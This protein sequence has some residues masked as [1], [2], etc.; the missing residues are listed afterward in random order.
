MFQRKMAY[1]KG[2][3]P[4]GGATTVVLKN[5]TITNR[6]LP[7]LSAV[8]LIIFLVH[9]AGVYLFSSG[10]L[11]SRLELDTVNSCGL[12]ELDK[13][14][15][16]VDQE[17]E[18]IS[19]HILPIHT[20]GCWTEGR[21]KRVVLIVVDALRFDFTVYNETLD[22]SGE[23][24][25][26]YLNKLP[27]IRD[28]LRDKPERS[29][30]VRVRADAPTTT[31]Q[32][33]KALTTGT[34]PTFVDAGSNFGVDQMVRLGKKISFMGDDTWVGLYPTQMNES[35]PYPSFN[36]QDLH[37]VDN[38]CV[39]HLFPALERQ[40]K[41]WD[42]L[43]A[44]FLGVD[45]VGH[46]F[47]PNTLPCLLDE[48]T[49]AFVIGDHGMDP[50]GDHGGDSENEVNAAL[51][52]YSGGK[53]LV[54]V[55]NVDGTD[56]AAKQLKE[57]LQRLE[58]VPFEGGEPYTYLNGHRTMPQI[59]LVPTLSLLIGLPIPFGN[60]GTIIPELF[61]VSDDADSEENISKSVAKLLE[62]TRMNARQMYRYLQDYSSQRTSADF[63]LSALK[64]TFKTFRLTKDE[65]SKAWESYYMYVV[66]M[67]KSLVVARRI[68]ARFDVPLI[69]MGCTVLG[70][71]LASAAV[72]AMLDWISIPAPTSLDR[73]STCLNGLGLRISDSAFFGGL[74]AGAF[75]GR[76]TDAA[77]WFIALLPVDGEDSVLTKT[78]EVL[79]LSTTTAMIAYITVSVLDFAR[80][81][82]KNNASS[83]LL[84]Q[85]FTA[86]K[87]G[88]VTGGT[89][90]NI[91]LSF[92]LLF[93][94]A[95][96][97]TSNSFTIHDE[98]V[99]AYLLQG[100]GL[101]TLSASFSARN[102]EARGSL[103]MHSILFMV[104]TR[105]SQTSTIC[106][107]ETLQSMMCYP[108]FNLVPNSSVAS[109]QAVLALLVLVPIVVGS[110]RASIKGTE[111]LHSTGA[112]LMLQVVPVGLSISAVYWTLDTFEGHHM[113]AAAGEKWAERLTNFKIWWAKLGFLSMSLMGL[114]IW[115]S[116]P[117]CIGLRKELVK[118]PPDANGV[119]GQT[120]SMRLRL[121]GVRNAMGA[122]YLVFVSIAY[123]VLV[124]FQKPLGGVMLGIEMLQILC[125][126][127]I[128]AVWREDAIRISEAEIEAAE[129]AAEQ[130]ASK[131]RI[132]A[133]IKASIK[134][135]SA[136]IPTLASESLPSPIPTT[137][138]TTPV[139]TDGWYDF[140]LLT[141][142][143]TVLTLVGQRGFFAT[144]HQTTISSIQWE[145][146]F[147]GLFSVN[148]Y[149]SPV[150]VALNTFGGPILALLSAPL[151]PLWR[152][153]V[154]GQ[155][156]GRTVREITWSVMW[157][158]LATAMVSVMATV[159]CGHFRRHLM[160]WKIFAPKFIFADVTLL[161][162]D[163]LSMVV[164]L[165]ALWLPWTKYREFLQTMEEKGLM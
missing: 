60:L 143:G 126:V 153:P 137:F 151:L 142:H 95:A 72:F 64:E 10:F 152:R 15:V 54:D 96:V 98:T 148:W 40:P 163:G 66:F 161:L 160:V 46:S 131:A 155:T 128:V 154:V 115:G 140:S 43:I 134:A 113:F 23:P 125:L 73:D 105:L 75:L 99:T 107:E 30:L 92:L 51:F 31:L 164:V 18:T 69:V 17:R 12:A 84:N 25:P 100:F 94:Y 62:S 32:R 14:L 90:A 138:S 119:A 118:S 22:K 49:V 120:A 68:W 45:H 129:S 74:L 29:L 116:D 4:N 157:H 19:S 38:G 3:E 61:M 81:W 111:N 101:Y 70:L 146:A 9:A 145:L 147:V 76:M 83:V 20:D 7:R 159:M 77:K 136:T 85:S 156:Q 35:H 93:L 47:G 122:A 89:I 37:T 117:V 44:H 80:F 50:K 53:K 42:F 106:R 52:V 121:F 127:E 162:V 63:Q 27:V 8:L 39:E 24:I 130:E 123:M 13:A 2:R 91:V 65:I 41:D 104:L 48:D 103:L 141:L 26:H 158:G 34:L 59:D 58:K 112:F 21:F 149:I 110:L 165:L 133:K 67:R 33:L 87:S 5:L 71:S 108:T 132:T 88:A 28:H 150:M 82:K 1:G 86:T 11:L 56:S 79:F 114:Y 6:F 102:D 78:H 57:L 97:P 124:M 109:P 16:D 144:G 139:A 135:S 55:E 36:V